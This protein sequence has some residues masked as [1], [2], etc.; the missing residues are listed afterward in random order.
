MSMADEDPGFSIHFEIYSKAEISEIIDLID[1]AHQNNL[2]F[3]NT[4]S[5]YAV[6][7][8]IVELPQLV[9]ILFNRN[10]S[11][12]IYSKFGTGYFI[13]KSI[14]FDK[15]PN[16]NWFVA[17]HQDL[18]IAVEK[19]VKMPGFNAWTVKHDQ[20]AVQPPLSLLVNNFTVRIHLDDT[21]DHNGALRVIPGSHM[22]GI[23]RTDMI[24]RNF[25][26][27]VICNVPGGGVMLMRPLLLHASSKSA[28]QTRRRVIHIEFSKQELPEPLQWA[29]KYILE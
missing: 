8:F 28:S 20:L 24:D 17:Y 25:D 14:Y 10:L 11:E 4:S 29:E 7:R 5:L 18:T 2:S 6:R 23:C 13:S 3:K 26:S 1:N 22:K 9:P 21:N 27:E 15:P 19:K 16:S 12:L